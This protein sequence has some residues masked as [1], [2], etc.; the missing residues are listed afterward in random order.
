MSTGQ[1]TYDCQICGNS[2]I[3]NVIEI[4]EEDIECPNCKS[5]EVKCT[6]IAF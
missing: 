1:Q 2:F 6:D 5:K 3:V 4:K